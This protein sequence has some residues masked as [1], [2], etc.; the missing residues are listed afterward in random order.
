MEEVTSLEADWTNVI[1]PLN[2]ISYF[3]FLIS[4]VLLVVA[5]IINNCSFCGPDLRCLEFELTESNTYGLCYHYFN[6]FF[7]FLIN[8]DF[9]KVVTKS[10]FNFGKAMQSLSQS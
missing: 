4:F 10:F 7:Y 2:F 6:V 3:F 1:T 5:E 8:S 9:V